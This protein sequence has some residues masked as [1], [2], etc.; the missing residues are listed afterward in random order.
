MNDYVQEIKLSLSQ[1][2]EEERDIG[3]LM[4]IVGAIAI[5]TTD[6]LQSNWTIGLEMKNLRR[7][8]EEI[9]KEMAG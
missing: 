8:Y 9:A 5:S 7:A 3:G 1:M 2:P 6:L 4:K